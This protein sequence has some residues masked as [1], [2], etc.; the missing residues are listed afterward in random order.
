M[1]NSHYELWIKDTTEVLPE[2]NVDTCFED[3]IEA[4]SAEP[5]DQKVEEGLERKSGKV[6]LVATYVRRGHG[7]V[8]EVA[9]LAARALYAHTQDLGTYNEKNVYVHDKVTKDTMGAFILV[10][11]TT[12]LVQAQ[13]NV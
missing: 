13:R 8:N 7:W 4:L 9:L 2:R 1:P 12:G 10:E 3:L 11:D 6:A 5:P